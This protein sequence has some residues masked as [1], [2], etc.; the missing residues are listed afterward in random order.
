MDEATNRA[1]SV[2]RSHSNRKWLVPVCHGAYQPQ[3]KNVAKDHQIGI[4]KS[5]WY[6]GREMEMR[7]KGKAVKEQ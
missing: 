7:L 4:C 1:D 6:V 5:S 3:I 2:E